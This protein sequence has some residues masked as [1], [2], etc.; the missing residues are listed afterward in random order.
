MLGYSEANAIY[1][2]AGDRT[3]FAKIK[4]RFNSI[5][6]LEFH[7]KEFE[8]LIH[9]GSFKGLPDFKYISFN[10]NLCLKTRQCHSAEHQTYNAFQKKS[11]KLGKNTKLEDFKNG[12]PSLKEIK[13]E[14]A[15]SL[16]AAAS[17]SFAALPA[18]S[19][20]GLLSSFF[21]PSL[22]CTASSDF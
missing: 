14:S 5:D 4:P 21:S 12:I 3:G 22:D 13:A 15:F 16:A 18:S 2:S 17:V 1:F 9:S 20:A 10:D 6:L 8:S 19:F 7:E 11:K